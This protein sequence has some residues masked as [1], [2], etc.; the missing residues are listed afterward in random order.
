MEKNT[1]KLTVTNL[2]RQPLKIEGKITVYPLD[3]PARLI[4]E[5]SWDRPDVFTMSREEF[6]KDFPN[7]LYDNENDPDTWK[8]KAVVLEKTFNSGQDSVFTL[9][10]LEPGQKVNM[11]QSWKQPTLSAKKSK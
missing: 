11:W 6:L 8:K 1:F 5:R 9:E 10:N 7:E 3:A 2:N 4:R